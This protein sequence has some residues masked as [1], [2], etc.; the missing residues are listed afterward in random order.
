[1]IIT[2]AANAHL[3]IKHHNS[4]HQHAHTPR[5]SLPILGQAP[6]GNPQVNL[7]NAVNA[8]LGKL[9]YR[10]DPLNGT[11]DYYNPAEFTQWQLEN[12]AWGYPCDCDDYAAYA[13]GL[14]RAAG[15]S[16][17]RL[18]LWTLVI[19][20]TQLTSKFWANHVVLGV[21]LTRGN[22]E[23]LTAVLDTNSAGSRAQPFWF[24]GRPDDVAHLVR[25]EFGQIYGV[26]Y[27]YLFQSKY[28]WEG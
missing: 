4:R 8:Q 27:S 25:A 14:M 18:K 6:A 12:E 21:E 24:P 9:R 26:T 15:V 7:T 22:D 11:L 23:T 16:Q 10:M 13:Y 28:P 17:A 19:D 20:W 3:A 1:M 2:L 5:R